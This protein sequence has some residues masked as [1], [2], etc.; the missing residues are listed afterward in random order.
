MAEN[1]KN[2]SFSTLGTRGDFFLGSNMLTFGV[3]TTKQ[4]E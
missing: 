1:E 4:L 2:P 3:D